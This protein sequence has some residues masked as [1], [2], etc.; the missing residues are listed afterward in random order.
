MVIT[1]MTV[2]EVSTVDTPAQKGAVAVI[3]KRGGP[4][5][6]IR[7]NAAE[8]ATGEAEPL[9]QA[10]EFGDAIMERAREIADETGTTPA[11]ALLIHSGKDRVLIELAI[12]ERAAEMGLMKAKARSRS[13]FDP[14]RVDLLP[15][16]ATQKRH[17]LLCEKSF[18]SNQPGKTH[19]FCERCRP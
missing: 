3:M 12:G 5:I 18:D 7:K 14:E 19:Q 13:P 9:Y 2:T 4:S 17:C 8:I 6:D 15:K 16:Q 1:D 11:K 10:S